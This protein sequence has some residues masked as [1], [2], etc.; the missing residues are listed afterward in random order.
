MRK[1]S[2]VALEFLTTYAWAFLAIL[3]IMGALYYFGVFDFSKFLPQKCIF[4]SQFECLDFSFTYDEATSQGQVKF[5]LVNN[6]GEDIRIDDVSVTND[7]AIPLT[8]TSPSGFLWNA[9]DTHDIT[10]TGC[11]GGVFISGQRTEAKINLE[12]C[13]PA[14]TPC[15][16]DSCSAEGCP[17]HAVNGKITAVVVSS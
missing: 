16:E 9:G 11:T 2:Q 6:L 4:P 7:A 15:T 5:K 12:Y 10:F 3:V 1:R 17:L 8:C 14:T 13:A